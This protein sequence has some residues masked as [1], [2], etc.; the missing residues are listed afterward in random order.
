MILCVGKQEG[1]GGDVGVGACGVIENSIGAQRRDHFLRRALQGQRHGLNCV[2]RGRVRLE[3]WQWH[4]VHL[5]AVGCG[6]GGG[7]LSLRTQRIRK[8]ALGALASAPLL[9]ALKPVL[10][11][12]APVPADV[13]IRAHVCACVLTRTLDFGM[14]FPEC[15]SLRKALRAV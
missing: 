11:C 10:L 9:L 12:E 6:R 8:A 2:R 13:C 7:A 1:K 3:V 14:V 15:V 4:L 5:I